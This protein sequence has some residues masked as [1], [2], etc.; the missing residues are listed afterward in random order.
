MEQNVNI[1]I[2]TGNDKGNNNN[3]IPS[4]PS[5][6]NVMIQLFDDISKSQVSNKL[7]YPEIINITKNNIDILIENNFN[8]RENIIKTY[9]L[10]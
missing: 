8:P 5:I 4:I 9:I 1:N 3:H 2:N 10:L 7:L 6:P